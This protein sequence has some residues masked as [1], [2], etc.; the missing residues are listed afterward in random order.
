MQRTK[1]HEATLLRTRGSYRSNEATFFKHATFNIFG[2]KVKP[3][4]FMYVNNNNKITV[5]GSYQIF[6][7]VCVPSYPPHK[8]YTW[9][10]AFSVLTTTNKRPS[11]LNYSVSHDLTCCNRSGAFFFFFFLSILTNL[12]SSSLRLQNPV[13]QSWI[14][15]STLTSFFILQKCLQMLIFTFIIYWRSLGI[16]FSFIFAMNF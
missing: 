4:L 11:I 10:Y 15:T 12:H 8:T 6:R 13:I 2:R 1:S 5:F 14:T 9:I 7:S 16:P 3:N